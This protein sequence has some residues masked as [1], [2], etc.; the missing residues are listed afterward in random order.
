MLKARIITATLFIVL[1]MFCVF[2]LPPSGFAA[3]S[4]L[5]FLYAFWEWTILAGF[6]S[7]ASRLC[8]LVAMLMI[9]LLGLL[10]LQALQRGLL[11]ELL[12]WLTLLF[13][14]LVPCFLYYFP[15]RS[16]Y[17]QSR[18]IG[19]IA[20]LF[21]LVPSWVAL[22]YLRNTDPMPIWVLYVLVIVW[23]ADIAAYFAGR[24]FGQ[25]KLAVDISPGKTWEGVA[26]ALLATFLVAILG[27]V[28][29]K[30]NLPIWYWLIL[31]L[32][33]TVFSVIGDLFESAFKRVR[34]LKDS[35]SILPGHG[36]LLDR[37]D[38][39]TSALPIF[40]IG[41]LYY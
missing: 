17:W 38:S 11:F 31:T 22:N 36:G 35:G 39:L 25:H 27:Y 12:P 29:L 37:L 10:L 21:V 24:R 33:T 3:I 4:S 1:V 41:F 32:M 14:L 40:A 5:F 18:T 20:G 28:V 8:C 15:S 7:T 2:F 16:L 26:G 19:F 34:H 13:W 30:P 23:V 6:K 9:V